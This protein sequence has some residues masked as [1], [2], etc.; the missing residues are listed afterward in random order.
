MSGLR[1]NKALIAGVCISGPALVSLVPM[2][3]APALPAMAAA[4]DPKG[5]GTL[6][7]QSIMTMPSIALIISAPLSGILAG[8]WGRRSVLLAALVL[9]AIGGTGALLAPTLSWLIIAR[10]VLGIA[11]GGVLATSLALIGRYFDGHLRERVLGF[12]TS[13]S[14]VTAALA[15][16]FGGRMV[17]LA[18]WRAP[19]SLY[20]F[21]IPVFL[22]SWLFIHPPPLPALHKQNETIRPIARLWP[23]YGLLALFTVGMFTPSIQGPFLIEANGLKSAFAQGLITSASSVVAI[24]AAASYGYLRNWFSA[25]TMLSVTALSYGI[26][27]TASTFLQGAWVGIGTGLVGIGGGIAEATIASSLLARLPQS[28]HSRAMGF[29]VTALFGGQWLNPW[30]FDPLRMHFGI[31]RAFLIVGLSFLALTAVIAIGGLIPKP[32][33]KET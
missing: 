14:S 27:I 32:H 25:R 7:A 31:H 16:I 20:L 13:L 18:G 24:I 26:G 5:D 4:L 10:L 11:A 15:L 17:D 21:A 22:A 1:D 9:F 33:P 2:A 3:A 8:Y 6:L 29:L 30:V 12:S 23:F 19:F 28:L